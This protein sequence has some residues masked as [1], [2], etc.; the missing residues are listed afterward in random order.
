MRTAIP[1]VMAVLL[2]AC[3]PAR[4]EAQSNSSSNERHLSI[5]PELD[6]MKPQGATTLSYSNAQQPLP[7]NVQNALNVLKDRAKKRN[8]F[9]GRN[10]QSLAPTE[11]LEANSISSG[12][13]AHILIHRPR[14]LDSSAI[15]ATPN[16]S[17]D[18]MPDATGLPSCRE[19]VR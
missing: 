6:W 19:G 1:A 12:P 17:A 5:R 16:A 14:N 15:A 4:A 9:A 3:F 10:G 13:C 2:L 7:P 11:T 18:R 8:P